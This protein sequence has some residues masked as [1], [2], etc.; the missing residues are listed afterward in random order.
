MSSIRSS[1][2]TSTPPFLIVD[3]APTQRQDTRQQR[4]MDEE[5]LDWG[6]EEDEQHILGAGVEDAEDA[7]SLGGDEDDGQDFAAYQSGSAQ[8]A[9]VT[10]SEFTDHHDRFE[11]SSQQSRSEREPSRATASPH[12]HSRRSQSSSFGQ[13]KHA[14]PPKPVLVAPEYARTAAPQMSTLAGPMVLSQR[15]SNG[16]TKGDSDS[17]DAAELL[18][19][20]WE[21]RRPRNGGQDVYYYNVKT[22]ESTWA[23]PGAATG[24]G[25]SPL[26]DREQPS[27]RSPRST[28]PDH[29][30]PSQTSDRNSSGR[31][32]RQKRRASPDA[33]TFGDRHYRPGE[34]TVLAAAPDDLSAPQSRAKS[35]VVAD[36]RRFRSLSPAQRTSD[37]GRR[38]YARSP[39]PANR[40]AWRDSQRDAPQ[41]RLSP[42]VEREH[43]TRGPNMP[44]ENLRSASPDGR[45]QR[46]RRTNI[47]ASPSRHVPHAQDQNDR[48]SDPRELSSA[49]HSTLSA[50]YP[51]TSRIRRLYPSRGGGCQY[52]DRLQK[53]REW[54]HS[55]PLSSL[56]LS[57][58]LAPWTH[59]LESFI[60]SL[61]HLPCPC[62]S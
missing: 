1:L 29:S 46:G 45:T 26:K 25:F 41:S 59:S 38:P 2:P 34:A 6:N 42:S 19:P 28:A 35:P 21:V 3:H 50:S 39:S 51:P 31:G 54:N 62:R 53:P 13:L 23:R 12:H 18:P 52:Y 8:D 5:T 9:E 30:T 43:W 33:L 56:G 36:D 11:A 15:R 60:F 14:L 57:P 17:L 27:A 44:V 32:R 48:H 10:H 49:P 55:V 4:Y 16:H 47:D 22:H 40:D 24:G 20:D 37:Y 61:F 7:V 58:L